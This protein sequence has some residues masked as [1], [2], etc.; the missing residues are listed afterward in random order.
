MGL[1]D[2]TVDTSMQAAVL[3]G[4]YEGDGDRIS[5]ISYVCYSN[6]TWDQDYITLGFSNTCAD[7]TEETLATMHCP[8]STD[9]RMS[10][11]CELHT[12]GGV[13]FSTG[14]YMSADDNVSYI[15]S[16]LA[17]AVGA[18]DLKYGAGPVLNGSDLFRAAVW[19]WD[20]RHVDGSRIMNKVAECSLG[21]AIYKYS[22]ISVVLYNFTIGATHKIPL[23]NN[24]GAT[25]VQYSSK[26]AL[27]DNLLW[28]NDTSP[29]QPDIH[30]SLLDLVALADFFQSPSFSGGQSSTTS[31]GNYHPGSAAIFKGCRYLND[32]DGH[33]MKCISGI[34]DQVTSSMTSQLL[35]RGGELAQGL[36]SQDVVYI[37]VRWVWLI[38]PLVVQFLGGVALVVTIIGRERTKNVPLWKSSTLAVLYHSV[39]EHGALV[40]CVKDPGQLDKIGKTVQAVLDQ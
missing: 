37:R 35:R 11:N 8:N 23:G 39:D 31:S 36:T 16:D 21:V 13:Q 6:C 25:L 20:D 10:N 38:L 34:F 2:W 15:G 18:S 27:A 28:W 33:F 1:I 22:N 29:D 30:V 24:S 12:P 4:L 7:V 5:D 9:A 32:D 17:V 40:A 26:P 14:D 3:K 19:I